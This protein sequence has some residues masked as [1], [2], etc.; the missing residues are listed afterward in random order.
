M[1]N[2]NDWEV[3]G[4]EVGRRNTKRIGEIEVGIGTRWILWNT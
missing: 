2:R 3:R 4:I 1:T